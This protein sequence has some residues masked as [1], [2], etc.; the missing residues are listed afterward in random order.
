MSTL[1]VSDLDGTLLNSNA[2]LSPA[3][4]EG[5]ER[6]LDRGVQFT[7]ASARSLFSIRSIL[8]DLPLQLPVISFNGGYLSNYRTGEHLV[9][10]GVEDDVVS[11]IQ[12]LLERR[13]LYPFVSTND[14]QHDHLYVGQSLNTAMRWFYDE[15]VREK[16]SRLR[17]VDD[18]RVAYQEVVTCISVMG[19]FAP[20]NAL[21]EE[22]QVQ[23][24]DRV[25]P[26]LFENL[27]CRGAFWLT[28]HPAQAT[29]A[30]GLKTLMNRSGLQGS[31]LVVFGDQHN[32]KEMFELAE[33]AVAVENA[34]P[35]LKAL[36]GVCIG[37]N[38]SDSVVQYL[39]HHALES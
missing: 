7:V 9:I 33:E 6:L 20:L 36:A 30:I 11:G 16:D 25:R 5:L 29:K 15:R 1:Y 38:D 26:H 17:Q 19:D 24:G 13:E 34:V 3:S 4:R 23:F 12:E 31:R 10:Y 35:E 14:G 2:E 8:G 21:L 22:I 27:Y 39:L 37:S 32:D 18:V 28:I